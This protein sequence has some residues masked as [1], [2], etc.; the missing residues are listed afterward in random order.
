MSR[1]FQVRFPCR[2]PPP[3]GQA[4]G[5]RLIMVSGRGF[6]TR[7]ARPQPDCTPPPKPSAGTGP[8]PGQAPGDALFMASCPG[9]STRA[10]CPGP[11]RTP[12]STPSTPASR[13]APR[14]IPCCPYFSPRSCC[15]MLDL[16]PP[17]TPSHATRVGRFSRTSSGIATTVSGTVRGAEAMT[18]CICYPER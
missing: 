3:P 4:P 12:P 1:K 11:D 15:P 18:G 7:A 5:G 9:F 13:T 17:S 8:P 6:S 14:F 16:S 10:S 2:A